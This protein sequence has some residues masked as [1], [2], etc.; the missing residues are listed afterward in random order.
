MTDAELKLCKTCEKTL[1]TPSID[2]FFAAVKKEAAY[3]RTRWAGDHD[4]LKSDPDWFWLI[5]YLAGKAL[6][7]PGNSKAKRLH[8]IVTVAAA[9]CNWFEAVKGTKP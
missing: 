6:H 4:K 9:A 5:G 1:G 8:R 7:N 2:D 3:Q